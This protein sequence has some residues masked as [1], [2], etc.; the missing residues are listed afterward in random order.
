MVVFSVGSDH[1]FGE[2]VGRCVERTDFLK[3]NLVVLIPLPFLLVMTFMSAKIARWWYVH[4]D[5]AALSA[6]YQSTTGGIPLASC[7]A[8]FVPKRVDLTRV[9]DDGT[10]RSERY[11][12]PEGNV[13]VIHCTNGK[14][15]S[16]ST[17]CVAVQRQMWSSILGFALFG[18]AIT[19]RMIRT[20]EWLRL[21]WRAS[22][23][24]TWNERLIA[25][26][27]FS[28]FAVSIVAPTLPCP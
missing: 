6:Q 4:V 9:D 3:R 24:M 23:P 19:L 5:R 11:V 28:I 26:Y 8:D 14:W 13:T 15:T 12:G 18:I 7:S 10:S 2:H 16:T 22:S 1:G 20:G 25:I 21:P 17:D 27:G